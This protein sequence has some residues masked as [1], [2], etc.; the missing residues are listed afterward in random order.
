MADDLYIGLISG[1]S[2]DGIDAVLVRFENEQATVVESICSSFLSELTDEIKSL[3]NPTTNEI[4]RLMALDVQLG[5]S[6]AEAVKQLLVKAKIK[7]QDIVAIGSHG[8]TI[9]HLPTAEHATTLQ[10]A[11]PNIIAEITGITTVADFRRRDMAA[12]GQGAPLVPAFHQ[13]LFSDTNK[14]R[15]ILNLGG[16]A[17]ITLLPADKSKAA[18]G[19]DT[20]TANTLMNH[21]IQQQ[22]NKPYDESGKWAASGT[23]NKDFLK[24]LL[25]DDYFKLAPPKST[26]TEYF[27]PTW[28]TKKLSA[29]LFLAAEDVQATLA[30]FTATTIKDAVNQYA[31]EAEE[32]IIC[33]GGVHN[34][35]LLQQLKQL[36][37][38]IE[39][40]SSEKYG[41]DPDYIEATAFAWLAKQTIEHKTGNLPEVTGAKQKVIL[42]GIFSA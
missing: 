34:N 32:I 31:S 4:N 39:I 40:N 25:D 37:P 1:T 35:F 24:E 14:T 5:N 8:Q 13:Q 23:I 29:F 22:E 41:L 19:F 16:I 42:G 30:A 17:N 33:G 36:L 15:V 3:I 26:G 9:R 18:T 38:N 20:G 12:G 10:I 7:K 6:F 27:N 21:W 28:L 11:D 2:L